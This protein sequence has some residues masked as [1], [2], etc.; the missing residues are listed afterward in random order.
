MSHIQLSGIPDIPEIS[1]GDDLAALILASVASHGIGI[2][3]GDVFVVAQ[4]VISKAEGRLVRLADIEPSALARQI[5]APRGGDPR[6]VEIVL[7]ESKAIVRMNDRLLITETHHGFICANAG[8]DRSNVADAQTVAL[9]PVDPDDSARRLAAALTQSLGCQLA[10]IITDTFGRPWREGLT[11]VAIGVAGISPVEDF[12]D[13][14]DDFGRTMKATVLAT[15]DEI[16]AASGLI[17]RK[18]RRQPVVLVRGVQADM[19][20]GAAAELIRHRTDDLFR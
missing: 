18:T 16:A 2:Q 17:M 10:V 12:R 3:A 11:N 7:R 8:V 15:A 19:R 14:P 9:L 6:F 4:K 13:Q 1:P 5:A 20:E